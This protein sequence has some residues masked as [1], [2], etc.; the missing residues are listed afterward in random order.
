MLPAA[1]F[2]PFTFTL[3]RHVPWADER[4][5]CAPAALVR[6]FVLVYRASSLHA[7]ACHSTALILCPP[8]I[9]P[10]RG[11]YYHRAWQALAVRAAGLQ[12]VVQPNTFALQL[13][14]AVAYSRAEAAADAFEQ[15]KPVF[16]QLSEEAA[17]GGHAPVT[18]ACSGAEQQQ[19]EKQPEKQPHKAEKQQQRKHSAAAAADDKENA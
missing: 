4:L 17:A 15:V 12:H 11:T 3:R 9:L 18:A 2:A 1:G 16:R 7:P 8:S 6:S 19:P 5:R 13:P 10:R 14:H